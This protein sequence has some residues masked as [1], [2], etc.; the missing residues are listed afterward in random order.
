MRFRTASNADHASRVENLREVGA[1]SEQHQ[2]EAGN[3]E[4][5]RSWEGGRR[6]KTAAGAHATS[7]KLGKIRWPENELRAVAQAWAALGARRDGEAS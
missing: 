5:Y 6:G 4:D 7:E 2:A 3:E 1:T